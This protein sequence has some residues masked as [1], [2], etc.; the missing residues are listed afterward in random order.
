MEVT[1]PFAGI[2]FGKSSTQESENV[3]TSYDD[4]IK[5]A[6]EENN[7]PYQIGYNL[8]KTESGLK[9]SPVNFSSIIF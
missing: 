5:Q 6:T 9:A 2:S 7:I 1:D 8:F 4:L 3:E